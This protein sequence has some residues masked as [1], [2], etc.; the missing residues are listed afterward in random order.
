[1]N[2]Y[3][4]TA[5]GFA[6]LGLILSHAMCAHVAFCY[7]DMLWGIQYAGYSAPADTAFPLALPYLAGMFAAFAM[8]FIFYKKPR[9]SA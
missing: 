5:I 4:A 1:M 2:T 3:R 6:A 7:C 9:K 8:A